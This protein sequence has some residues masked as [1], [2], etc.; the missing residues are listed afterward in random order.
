MHIALI[1]PSLFTLPYDGALADGFTREGHTVVLHG[2]RLRPEDGSAAGI[3]LSEDFYR[4]AGGRRVM[5]LPGPL[6]LAVKGVDHAWSMRRLLRRLERE[7]PDVIH[8]QWLPLPMLDGL[9]LPRFRRIAPLVLTV[10]DTNPFNGDP[11]A[12][13]QARGFRAALERFDRLVVHTAQGRARLLAMGIPPSRVA[14]LPHGLLVDPVPG[15]PDPMLGRLDFLLFGKIKPYK[16]ADLLIEAFAALPE[17]LRAQARLRIVGK[18]YMD[19]A[20]LYA[21]AAAR[22]I[23]LEIEQG[24]VADDALPALFGSGTVA[25]FPYREIEASGVMFLA[26]AHGRPMIASRLGSF[27]ELLADGEHGCLLPPGDVPALTQAMQRMLTDRG[28]AAG[29]AGAVRALALAVPGWDEI[30][31]RTAQL[32]RAAG[33]ADAGAMETGDVAL[34]RA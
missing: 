23:A 32:Y 5:A 12:A 4:V 3:A 2:R 33:A 22:G 18:A 7:R 24:F 8:F 26:I 1:D 20:P 11:S 15:A 25:M 29:C 17:A 9:L 28:F 13:L 10:H 30:A 34:A 31:R 27:G 14:V 16:G 21:L 19:L 6:R